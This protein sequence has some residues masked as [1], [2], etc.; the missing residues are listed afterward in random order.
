[1]AGWK[2]C[3]RRWSTR[4]EGWTVLVAVVSQWGPKLIVVKGFFGGGCWYGEAEW[5][6]WQKKLGIGSFIEKINIGLVGLV[7]CAFI[8]VH[9]FTKYGANHN[10]GD[11]CWDQIFIWVNMI[12]SLSN[13]ES[14][15]RR[16]RG[17]FILLICLSWRRDSSWGGIHQIHGRIVYDT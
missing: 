2:F 15:N 1:M 13:L 3:W 11:Y 14:R 10:F 4:E 5:W 16:K 9:W 7:G 17:W 12:G 6:C 8:E